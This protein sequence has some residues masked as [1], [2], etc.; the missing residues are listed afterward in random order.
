MKS[1]SKTFLSSI[2]LCGIVLG[3]AGC[4]DF[5]NSSDLQEIQELKGEINRQKAELDRQ[6]SELQSLARACGVPES[7]IKSASASGLISEIKIMLDNLKYYGGTLTDKEMQFVIDMLS[8]EPQTRKK[9][10]DYDAF[11]KKAKKGEKQ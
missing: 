10:Q 8:D 3:A 5:H 6:K 1:I 11:I 2:L 9:V 4:R 7:S